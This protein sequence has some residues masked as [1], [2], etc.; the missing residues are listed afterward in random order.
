MTLWQTH[1]AHTFRHSTH[2]AGVGAGKA[3]GLAFRAK[4]HDVAVVVNNSGADQVIAFNQIYRA[5]TDATGTRIL[6]ETGLFNGAVGGCHEYKLVGAVFFDGQYGANALAFIKRQQVNHRAT[7]RVATGHGNL[8]DL[9]PVHF[10]QVGK[11]QNSGVSAG[12]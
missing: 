3:H 6:L 1:A 9:E 2:G 10:T 12:Y 5:Q 7:A 11:A 4:Q 8:V